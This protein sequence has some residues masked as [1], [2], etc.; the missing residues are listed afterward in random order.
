MQ[1]SG[2]ATHYLHVYANRL[3]WLLNKCIKIA[4]CEIS[5]IQNFA[6]KNHLYGRPFPTL[7]ITLCVCL[8]YLLH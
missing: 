7:N 4:R 8:S 2:I 5:C 1:N 3:G 6:Y